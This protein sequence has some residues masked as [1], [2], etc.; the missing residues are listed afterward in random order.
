VAHRPLVNKAQRVHLSVLAA[1]IEETVTE[2]EHFLDRDLD[3]DSVLT[4]YAADVPAGF[5]ERV[6]PILDQ[7]RAHVA[8]FS[9]RFSLD[10]RWF[11][12]ASSIEA[13]VSAQ[14]VRLD[15]S[16]VKQ[17]RG[18]GAV[19][20]DLDAVLAPELEL[21]RAAFAAIRALLHP[22]PDVDQASDAPR[23]GP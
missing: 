2:I 14:I 13:H 3:R 9:E 21:F 5:A 19:S 11:S 10:S 23:G 12:R 18:Y 8:V 4:S 17:L 15:E 16:G 22:T 1:G 20:E 7:L 6:G